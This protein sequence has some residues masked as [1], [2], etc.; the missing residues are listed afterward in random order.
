[1]RQDF[2]RSLA[3]LQ[4]LSR[5]W[6]DEEAVAWVAGL[7]RAYERWARL[8]EQLFELHENPLKNRPALRIARVQVQALRVQILDQIDTMIETQKGRESTLQNRELLADLVGFQISFDAMATNL[9]AYGASGEL[10]FKLGYGPQLATNAAIWNA[11]S[12]R[13]ERLPPDQQ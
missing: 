9:M 4:V 8:P 12:A 10:N 6:A 2:E 1:A 5:S 13:R 3:A 11:L 7:T